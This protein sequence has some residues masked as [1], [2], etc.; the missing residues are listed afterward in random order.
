LIIFLVEKLIDAAR[1]GDNY[2]LK[3]ILE[4]KK[5]NVD[6]NVKHLM[7]WTALHV[8]AMNG[9]ASTVKL[10]LDHGADVEIEEEFTTAINA[11]RKLRMHS[12]EGNRNAWLFLFLASLI[13]IL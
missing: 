4:K 11:A 9:H 5:S 3:H 12:L 6:V 13:D 10:L 1:R 8:A 7:G 2:E